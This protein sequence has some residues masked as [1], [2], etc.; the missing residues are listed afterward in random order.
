MMTGRRLAVSLAVV[1]VA[2]VAGAGSDARQRAESPQAVR[3][4]ALT[5]LDYIEI[6]QL[7]RKYT[8][9]MDSADDFGY[10]YADLFTPDGVFMAM[11]QGATGRS[12][13]GRDELATIGRG[14]TR[15]P[16]HQSHFVMNHVI[17]PTAGGATGKAY[18]VVLDVGIVGTPN[19]VNHGGHYDD[20]YEKTPV[21]WRFR[22]RTYFESKVDVWPAAA[23]RQS[24]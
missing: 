11:N 20:V 18:V 22:K 24:Q 21:G 23:P 6:Q 14:G 19:G 1:T 9:A 3:L 10:A 12:Y 2:V 17:T 13:A 5:T 4:A 15:G 8:W 16:N 7:V